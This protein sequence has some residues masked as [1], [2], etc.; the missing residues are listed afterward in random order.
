MKKVTIFK[1]S[2]EGDSYVVVPEFKNKEISIHVEN[3]IGE[4]K[5]SVPNKSKREVKKLVQSDEFKRVGSRRPAELPRAGA[6]KVVKHRE[7]L[8]LALDPIPEETRGPNDNET[9]N[10]P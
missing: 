5:A 8:E 10:K 2:T 3:A 9:Q 1:L 7:I 6:V 4:Q